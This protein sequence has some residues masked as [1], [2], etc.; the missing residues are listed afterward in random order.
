MFEAI[1]YNLRHVADF[2]GR[3]DRP[4]F[5][6]YVLFLLVLDIL[7]GLAISGPM[8]AETFSAALNAAQSG[9]SQ[10]AIQ[11]QVMQRMS[12]QAMSLVWLSAAIKA[13]IVALAV[14]AFVRRLHDSGN[15]GWWAALAVGAQVVAFVVSYNM[16]GTVTAA[17]TSAPSPADL[18]AMAQQMH[19]PWI[20]LIGWVAPVVVLVFGVM[21]S[22]AGAN[23]YGEAPRST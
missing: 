1:K 8:M 23:R 21:K 3:E 14:A 15:S 12:E 4:T 13:L 18:T 11:A 20:G 10:E 7:L 5:W 6:W 9:A 22:S 2:T 17:M 16:L 19:R